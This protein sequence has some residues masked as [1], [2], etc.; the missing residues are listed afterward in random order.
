MLKKYQ[1]AKVQQALNNVDFE[2]KK[3]ASKGN[4]R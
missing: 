1:Q 2:K 4:I 3:Q